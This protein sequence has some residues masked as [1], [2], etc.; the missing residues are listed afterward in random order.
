MI[1]SL[2]FVLLS[3]FGMIALVRER[4][5]RRLRDAAR[6]NSLTGVGSRRYF[7]GS[8]QRQF[9]RARK[10]RQAL[11][12]IMID[13]DDFKAYNDSY[14]HPAGDRCLRAIAEA[15]SR[16]CRPTD[17][18]GRYG[19][20]EFAVLLP[21]T[22]RRTA[23]SV[24]E[25]MRLRVRALHLAHAHHPET[26]VTISLGIASLIPWLREAT[27]EDLVKMADRALYLAKETG[28]D[29]TC[30]A[31]DEAGIPLRPGWD[32]GPAANSPPS[33]PFS[34]DLHDHMGES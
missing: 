20:E 2:S 13:V 7:E 9:L 6:I 24:A 5:E 21:D 32:L 26:M 18:V 28:R 17:M 19:G 22:D 27:P 10:S 14:G 34:L 8:L 29:R 33:A 1:N 15:L 11:G 31:P 4:S 30:Q 23:Y 16:S 25:R 12:L 3:S